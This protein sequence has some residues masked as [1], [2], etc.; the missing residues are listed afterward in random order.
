MVQNRINALKTEEITF[1]SNLIARDAYTIR[2]I[3]EIARTR[4]RQANNPR[5]GTLS[6]ADYA[7]VT[8]VEIRT[9]V[10]DTYSIDDH[11][12]PLNNALH[13]TNL[14]NENYFVKAGLE[15]LFSPDVDK[16]IDAALTRDFRDLY[17]EQSRFHEEVSNNLARLATRDLMLNFSRPQL[18]THLINTHNIDVNRPSFNRNVLEHKVPGLMP[19]EFRGKLNDLSIYQESRL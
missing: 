4:G 5:R 10:Q 1:M 3:D 16:M 18:A 14:N 11:E 12:H 6:V 7:R 2:A 15:D 13:R 19:Y 9:I 8:D 17:A